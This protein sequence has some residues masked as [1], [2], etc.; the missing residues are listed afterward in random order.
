MATRERI[1]LSPQARRWLEQPNFAFLSTLVD[2]GSPHVS[3]VW[4]D[5]E[6]DDVVVNTAESRLK[7]ENV[8]CDPRVALSLLPPD[9]RYAH[10]DMTRCASRRAKLASGNH[11]LADAGFA[12][13]EPR[14]A[15]SRVHP[16]SEK[17]RS[18]FSEAR[19]RVAR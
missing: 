17:A 9:N 16:K 5:V 11:T 3:P 14:R 6:G 2:D 12:G 4:V 19:D 13:R 1:R 15:Q 18:A 8:H 10:V 7:A